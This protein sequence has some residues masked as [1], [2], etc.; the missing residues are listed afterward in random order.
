MSF[1]PS[2]AAASLVF[3][4]SVVWTRIYVLAMRPAKCL[5][6]TTDPRSDLNTGQIGAKMVK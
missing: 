2:G 6:G 4:T 5:A 3:R 1:R